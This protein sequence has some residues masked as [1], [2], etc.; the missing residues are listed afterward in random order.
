MKNQ[1][2]GVVYSIVNTSTGK[3]Y[4]G[5]TTLKPGKRFTNHTCC[6]PST[7][8]SRDIKRFGKNQFE[9]RILKQCHTAE[10][11]NESERFF[12]E[13]K[14]KESPTLLYNKVVPPTHIINR[15]KSGLNSESIQCGLRI[16]FIY[17]E[18]ILKKATANPKN[19]HNAISYE[20]NK[21][22]EDDYDKH[23]P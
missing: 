12:Y 17:Y 9:T 21:L 23:N 1:P 2:I 10:E 19:V 4:I 5:Q 6:S 14:K 15:K 3:T 18:H 7:E 11:L 20:I 13:K 22:I 8:L 16:K